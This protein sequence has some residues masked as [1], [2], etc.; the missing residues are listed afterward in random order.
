[1]PGVRSVCQGGGRAEIWGIRDV[2]RDVGGEELRCWSDVGLY[3]SQNC[4]IPSSLSSKVIH[5]PRVCDLL[6]DYVNTGEQHRLAA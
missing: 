2:M 4:K 1:M 6:P 5:F 3:F